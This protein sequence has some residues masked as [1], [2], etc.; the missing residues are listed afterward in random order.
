MEGKEYDYILVFKGTGHGL[1]NRI[2]KLMLLLAISIFIFSSIFPFS[3][4]SILPLIITAA[5]IGWWVYLYL[6]QK[7]GNILYYRIALMFAAYGWYIQPKGL[8]IALVYLVAALLEKQVKF[9]DEVAFDNE[10]IVFNSFPKKF[11]PWNTFRN[12]VLKDG[13]LT[14]DFM[15]N[16][17][18]QKELESVTTKKEEEE[19]N[20]FCRA[21][22]SPVTV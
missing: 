19:F 14:I 1:V 4:T 15:N 9:P 18:I 16:K 7:K 5:I 3:K 12:I 11:Y 8:L 13:L 6:Q 22:L 17:L 21:R 2:S 10:E 20:E